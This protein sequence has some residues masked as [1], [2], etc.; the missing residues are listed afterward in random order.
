M[1]SDAFV[2]LHFKYLQ[3]PEILLGKAK[4]TLL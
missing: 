4:G 3:L 2:V 1:I